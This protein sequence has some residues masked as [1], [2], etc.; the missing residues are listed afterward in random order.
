MESTN[1]RLPEQKSGFFSEKFNE[2]W[3]GNEFT[4]A[5]SIPG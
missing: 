1:V 4:R 3:I 2:G 5:C